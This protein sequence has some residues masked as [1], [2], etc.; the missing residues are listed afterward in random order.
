V[1]VDPAPVV[2]KRLTKAQYR[3]SIQDLFGEHIAVPIS[4]EPDVPEHGFL[5]VGGSVS[6]ISALGVERYE[7]A[8]F[9][10]AAQVLEPGEARDALM[11]CEPSAS[12]DV[13]CANLFITRV[14]REVFRRPLTNDEVARY[15]SVW[16]QAV[17]VLAA[18]DGE[19]PQGE[20]PHFYDGLTFSLAGL[21]QSP[22]FL[23][24]VELGAQQGE[25]LAYTD[26][27]MATRLSYF[28][29][30]TTPAPWLLDAAERGELNDD[31]TL[32]AHIDQML[33]SNK[34][35]AGIRNFF[36]ERFELH[37]LDDL[38]KDGEV[39]TSHSA[40]LGPEAREE[41]LTL[42][43]HAVFDEDADYRD[44]FTTRTTFLNRRLAALYGVAAPAL[45]GF[46]QTTHA[47]SSPRAG[48][49]GHASLLALYAHS[50]STSSTLR[51]KFIRKVLLCGEIPPPPA[52]VDTSL[53]EPSGTMPTLRDRIQEHLVNP[54]CAACHSYMDP[55]GL[56]LEQFDGLGRFRT[57]E[58][59]HPID[60]SGDLD[61]TPFADAAALGEVIRNHPEVSPCLVRHLY[62]Y[63][64]AVPEGDAY[65]DQLG[66]LSEQFAF[67]GYRVLPLLAR[68]ALSKGF[69]S[70]SPASNEI[71][72]PDDE[73][74]NDEAPNDEGSP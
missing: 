6:G 57:H 4:L 9:D 49:L 18:Q 51:G 70:A 21:L 72:G 68:I 63:A 41:T 58:N 25:T 13:A 7:T 1:E 47:E 53:P 24:R 10:L 5:T 71:T 69:R 73:A 17:A 19:P 46:A 74:P 32:S 60:P 42:I 3:N 12:D 43:E 54:S 66:Q 16:A 67:E 14:G 44:L 23:F 40:D 65:E 15:Q 2:L 56:G 55:I 29:W 52:D 28:L 48:L 11:P 22:H 36:S 37:L 62:R 33:R 45:E 61:G 39:F 20:P 26:Y 34:A 31:A 35:R 59:D 8:A 30:N 27:E 64:L 50:A 38:V